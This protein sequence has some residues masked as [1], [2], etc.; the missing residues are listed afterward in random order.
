MSC[1]VSSIPGGSGL[2]SP[3]ATAQEPHQ[4]KMP[5]PEVQNLMLGTWSTKVHYSPAPATPNGDTGEGTEVG[6]PA[7]EDARLS[8]SLERRIREARSRV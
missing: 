4:L 1:D 2:A 5:G 3:A 7:Q 8:K 6:D